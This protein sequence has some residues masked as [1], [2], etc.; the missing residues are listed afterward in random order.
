MNNRGSIAPFVLFFVPFVLLATGNAAGYRYGASDLAFY[1]PAVMRELDPRLFPRDTPLIDAQARLTLMDETVAAIARATTERLPVLFVSL[2]VATLAMLAWGASAIGARLYRSRWTIAVLLALLTFRHAIARSGTNS[3]EGYFHPR[4]LA[5]AFGAL[6]IAAFLGG[7]YLLTLLALGGA[8]VLHPTTTLWLGIWLAVALFVAEPR[9]RKPLGAAAALVGVLASWALAA[10]PLAGR[11]AVMDAEWLD[12]IA[13][14]QYLFPTQWPLSAW[15]LNL[16]YIPIVW[17]V[18]RWRESSGMAVS[19]ERGLAIGGLALAA[20]FFAAVVFNA[21]HVALAIQLQPARIFWML[22]FLA[23]IYGAWVI[24][25]ESSSRAWQPRAAFALLVAISIARATYVMQVEFPER[26][27]F[28]VGLRGDWGR[29]AA[30]A[31]ATPPD[32]GWLADPG[33]ASRYG[34]SLRMAAGRDV[35]V[36]ASKDAAI[37]MYDRAIA[38]RTRDRIKM[39]DPYAGLTAARARRLGAE[40]DLDYAISESDMA[41]PIAFQSGAIKVYRL[42]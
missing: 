8:A 23:A 6:A 38:M 14:K 27:L 16:S 36:E 4:Q 30:W 33:H 31:A 29:V 21:A 17:F 35:F 11:L 5:F 26:P 42:R 34:T 7:R 18:Y 39:V 22:D 19:R 32:T 40:L 12:A 41:L 13:D 10:G 20:L 25:G 1:G 37:G 2:Y 24:S 15:I 28:D 3:L 9:W